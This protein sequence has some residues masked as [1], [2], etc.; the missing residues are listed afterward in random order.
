MARGD[1]NQ[2]RYVKQ[3]VGQT[4]EL[5]KTCT[6]A[7]LKSMW[8]ER[9]DR[10][11]IKTPYDK[12]SDAS[13]SGEATAGALTLLYEKTGDEAF[14]TALLALRAYELDKGG[15]KENLRRLMRGG[16]NARPT[17]WMLMPL[18]EGGGAW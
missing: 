5:P 17:I 18:M 12:F 16:G 3:A 10:D 11:P 9:F 4:L 14:R 8:R 7:F 1:R 15:L 13:L 2:S 6:P